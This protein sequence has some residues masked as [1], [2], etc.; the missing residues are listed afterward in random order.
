MPADS[1]RELTYPEVGASLGVL[2]P[3][4]RHLAVERELGNGAVVFDVAVAR[5]F[6]WE[7]HRAAGLRVARGT[8]SAAV[9]VEVQL[10]FG[11]GPLRLPAWCRVVEVVDTPQRR[12][13]TYGTLSGH[14]EIGEESFLVEHR[15]DGRVVG[16]VTAFSR[17]GRWYTRL[18]APLA[19]RLQH[20]IAQKYLDGLISPQR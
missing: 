11:V 9:G 6:A 19:R 17:P 2:P 14:P 3:G 1:G 20:R 7:M 4:Y 12:G 18:A 16:Q 10:G 5:L 13:F 8:P 15:P